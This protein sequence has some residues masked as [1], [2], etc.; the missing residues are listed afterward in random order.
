MKYLTYFINQYGLTIIHTITLSIL[1]YI[2]LEIKK[3]YQ[4]YI[5]NKIKQETINTVCKAIN[6][7]YP[8]LSKEEKLNKIII[9]SQKILKEKNITLS[10]LELRIY[11]EAN[12]HDLN[13]QIRNDIS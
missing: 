10:K 13:K 3:T 12:K 7:L 5:N 6:E 2:S 8:H 4:K 11:I 1:S 9:N